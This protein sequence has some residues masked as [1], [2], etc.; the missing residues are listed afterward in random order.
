M[1]GAR[2]EPAGRRV[3]ARR[4]GPAQPLRLAG[5]GQVAVKALVTGAGG[6]LG[7]HVVSPSSSAGWRSGRMVRP[8]AQVESLGWPASVEVFRAD[9][10]SSRRTSSGLRRRGRAG[11]PGGSG[12]RRRGRPVRGHG[13][14]H[15]SGCSGDG[16]DRLHAGGAGEQLL[17][18]RLEPIDGHAR[19]D[20]AARARPGPLRA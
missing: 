14:R 13:G 3:E 8:A 18:L 15:R 1:P 19:R 2:G 6:F 12:Q 11:P 9:L 17:G 10:R 5:G 20:L 7:R 4:G 16:A